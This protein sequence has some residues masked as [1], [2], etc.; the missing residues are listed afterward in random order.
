MQCL[1]AF[2][3]LFSDDEGWHGIAFGVG[4]ELL[5]AHINTDMQ[6]GGDVPGLAFCMYCELA[7]ET[8]STFD[9]TH[10]FD[11]LDRECFNV[12]RAD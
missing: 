7:I 5:Q 8:I 2:L 4:Q 9:E 12:T 10:A 3:W 1:Q 11:V 6:T